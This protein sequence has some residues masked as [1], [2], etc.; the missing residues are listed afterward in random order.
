MLSYSPVSLLTA[1]AALAV[2]LGLIWLMALAARFAGF[3]PRCGAAG[4]LIRVQE[5][6]SSDTRRRLHLIDCADRQVLLLTGASQDLVVGWLD[7][8]PRPEARS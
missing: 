4:R 8:R 1:A 7:E 2:V 6:I 5:S 3:A